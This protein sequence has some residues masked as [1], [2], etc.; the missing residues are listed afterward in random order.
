LA[1]LPHLSETEAAQFA[2]D[3]TAAREALAR[4]EAHDPWQS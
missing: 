1:S 2:A 3:L 4:T